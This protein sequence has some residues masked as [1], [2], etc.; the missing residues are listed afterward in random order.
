[1]VVP[2]I[3]RLLLLALPL[4]ML[5]E[6]VLGQE[7]KVF[8]SEKTRP[9][10]ITRPPDSDGR[11]LFFTGRHSQ[12]TTID[13]GKDAAVKDAA[14]QIASY[15]GTKVSQ[16]LII[17]SEQT[18]TRIVDEIRASAKGDLS[19]ARL[20]GVYW[21]QTV[22]GLIFR[23]SDFNVWVLVS[24]PEANA[25]RERQRLKSLAGVLRER[26]GDVC[27]SFSS[28]IAKNA[29]GQ[30]VRVS[31]FKE[32]VSNKRYAFS[33]IIETELADSLV[34]A[35]VKVTQGKGH[36]LLLTGSFYRTGDSVALSARLLRM[37]DGAGL[38]ATA[39]TIAQD[40]IEPNWLKLEET[41]GDDFFSG[42]EQWKSKTHRA[43]GALS[44]DSNPR[45]AA[46]LIDGQVKARTPADVFD[47]DIGVHSVVFDLDGYELKAETVRVGPDEKVP[48]SPTLIAKAGTLIIKTVP[49]NAAVYLDRD[50]RGHS[51]FSSKV[52]I[53]EH[54]VLVKKKNFKDV[55]FSVHVQH[56]ATTERSVTLTEEKGSLV[57][58]SD[59]PGAVVHIEGQKRSAGKTPLRL[60][61]FAA[62]RHQ[63]V[64]SKSG[65]GLWKGEAVVKANEPTTVTASLRQVENGIVM[66]TAEP[67]AAQLYVDGV[68]QFKFIGSNALPL[69]EGKR[70]IELRMQGYSTWTKTITV[71]AG[72]HHDLSAKLSRVFYSSGG[73]TITSGERTTGQA[74]ARGLLFPGWGQVYADDEINR[75][76]A[77]FVSVSALIGAGFYLRDRRV[78]T[79]GCSQ[80][81]VTNERRLTREANIAWSLALMVHLWGAYDSTRAPA[82]SNWTVAPRDRGASVA[83]KR[84]F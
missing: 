76:K 56:D 4:L 13:A 41:K 59:P 50:P 55:R 84:K 48:L 33:R 30:T 23:S 74:L 66:I 46:V 38:H 52:A 15:I 53:G 2:R 67:A 70:R 31:G 28:W 32:Q 58:V 83:W 77:T 81:C 19:G 3:R 34:R 75:G 51:P 64:V 9:D 72:T 6:R 1:M 17:H 69:S 44:L 21:E 78:F 80:R 62:G 49:S 61:P 39:T 14:A 57:V 65:F 40:A 29:R 71:K 54:E 5:S 16:K 79:E 25:I 8:A 26:V 42:L 82:G 35:G 10:W 12:A 24:Y 27:G 11:T 18:R 63:V 36:K 20:A 47:I 37:T 43:V 68:R 73:R 7:G 60:S 45:G 22:R